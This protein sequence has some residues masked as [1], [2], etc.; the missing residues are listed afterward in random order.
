VVF[1]LTGV[2]FRLTGVHTFHY[3]YP[4]KPC[5]WSALENGNN[6]IYA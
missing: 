3:D 6:T 1:K 4:E 5:L 2:I